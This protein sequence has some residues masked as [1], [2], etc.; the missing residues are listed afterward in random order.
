M[1][2]RHFECFL[3]LILAGVATLQLKNAEG[4]L[5]EKAL[6]LQETER[7][8]DRLKGGTQAELKAHLIKSTNDLTLTQVRELR[9]ARHLDASKSAE[10]AYLSEK[11]V[12]PGSSV[13]THHVR[14]FS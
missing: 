5:R 1:F 4:E 10:H 3:A 2:L 14:G 13:W 11:Q 8:V 9:L 7:L 6:Q 12:R